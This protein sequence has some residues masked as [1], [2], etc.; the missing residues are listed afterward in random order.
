MKYVSDFNSDG[1]TLVDMDSGEKKLYTIESF[2][3]E[4]YVLDYS[5]EGVDTS[6]LIFGAYFEN[7]SSPIFEPLSYEQALKCVELM[8]KIKNDKARQYLLRGIR[9]VVKPFTDEI[10]V[11]Y[12]AGNNKGYHIPKYVTTLCDSCF[13]GVELP[14]KLVI[15]DNVKILRSACFLRVDVS[16]I[17]CPASLQAMET[18][19]FF[20]SNIGSFVFPEEVEFLSTDVFSTL[21]ANTVFHVPEKLYIQYKSIFDSLDSH[22]NPVNII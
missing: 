22:Y 20:E 16:E 3:D 11:L 15:P 8:K 12:R 14:D 1:I 6:E 18:A 2:Y 10:V 13:F 4:F 5:Q 7:D 21:T 9:F 19:I 17:R